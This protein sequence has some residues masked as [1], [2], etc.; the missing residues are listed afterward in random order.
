MARAVGREHRL[1]MNELQ[2]GRPRGTD[3]LGLRRGAWY[4]VVNLT[5]QE[6]VV[7]VNR[8]HVAVPRVSLTIV[9]AP[10]R[11]WTVVT[12]PRDV[13]HLP[14]DWGQYYAVCPSCRTRAPLKTAPDA[15]RCPQCAGTF[16]VG[17][18]DWYLAE[19]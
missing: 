12:R 19:A 8:H 9:S 2:W 5:R 18:E 15:M 6:A 3:N 11:S 10:P 7:E 17:W 1:A 16:R 13:K 14:A 4:R